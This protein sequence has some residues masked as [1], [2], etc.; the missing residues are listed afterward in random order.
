MELLGSLGVHFAI[1][2]FHRRFNN[3]RVTLRVVRKLSAQLKR[4]TQ[5]N[6]TWARSHRRRG[7]SVQSS[8]PVVSLRHRDPLHVVAL[9]SDPGVRSCLRRFLSDRFT[10]TLLTKPSELAS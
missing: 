1:E 3:I 9:D 5:H 6:R 4:Q 2:G 8:E 10:L 7:M